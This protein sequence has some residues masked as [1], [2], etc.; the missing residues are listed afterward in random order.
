MEHL[1]IFSYSLVIALGLHTALAPPIHP[2]PSHPHLPTPHLVLRLNP[3]GGR[4]T[5]WDGRDEG[6][7]REVGRPD[8]R[9]G[10]VVDVLKVQ[11]VFAVVEHV[12]H[13]VGQHTRHYS[14]HVAHVLANHDLQGTPL[15][16]VVEHVYHLEGEH[17][18]HGLTD[19]T[20]LFHLNSSS[21]SALLWDHLRTNSTV[22]N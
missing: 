9:A 4:V 1:T 21:L 14:V 12:Y 15:F 18:R 16:T 17:T 5:L 11:L 22:I 6:A 13:L 10:E 19:N 2:R 3:D 7:V 8:L 20:L